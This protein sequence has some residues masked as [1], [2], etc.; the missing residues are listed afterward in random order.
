MGQKG[1][2]ETRLGAKLSPEIEM[3]KVFR[4]S[5]FSG[6]RCKKLIILIKAGN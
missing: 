4:F 6:V 3:K 1:V 2:S 5:L